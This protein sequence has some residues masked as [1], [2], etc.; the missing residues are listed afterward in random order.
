[1]AK[2]SLAVL[3]ALVASASAFAPQKAGVKKTSLK[4]ADIF[5]PLGLYELGS[6]EA[7]DVFPGVFPEKQYLEASEA[8][9]GRQ[10]MLAWTGVWATSDV[11]SGMHG[12]ATILLIRWRWR[13]MLTHLLLLFLSIGRPWSWL[14]LPWLPHGH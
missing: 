9:H 11:S 7:F 13:V 6:G 1:M 2:F 3:S 8:K 5:D 12:L 10:A 4:A 14:A